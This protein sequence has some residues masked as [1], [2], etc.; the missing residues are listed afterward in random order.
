ME[1]PS[2]SPAEPLADTG[3]ISGTVTVSNGAHL[4]QWHNPGRYSRRAGRHADCR[5]S[6]IGQLGHGQ[7]P[8]LG[9]Q[10]EWRIEWH[11][12]QYRDHQR[13]TVTLPSV[14]GSGHPFSISLLNDSGLTANHTGY[15]FTIINA[16]GAITYSA[17][18]SSLVYNTDFTVSAPDYAITSA[19]FTLDGSN[20]L[21]LHFNT[22]AVVPEPAHVLLIAAAGLGLIFMVRRRW[23][24]AAPASASASA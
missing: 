13:R 4:G 18:P 22:G 3:T 16:L 2:P 6:D 24:N 20:D 11:G 15:S 7:R 23:R 14:A 12:Q 8:G 1:A 9:G 5:E 21:V 17:T 10:F 19:S